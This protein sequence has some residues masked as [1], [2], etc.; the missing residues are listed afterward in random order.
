M[1]DSRNMAMMGIYCLI[2]GMYIYILYWDRSKTT[3]SVTVLK[4][5]WNSVDII[6]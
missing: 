1:E 2:I 5:S 3:Y 4:Y 6:L